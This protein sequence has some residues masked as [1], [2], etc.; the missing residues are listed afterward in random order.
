ME[1]RVILAEISP[2]RVLPGSRATARVERSTRQRPQT[3]QPL[4]RLHG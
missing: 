2:A 1:I 4:H 3:G